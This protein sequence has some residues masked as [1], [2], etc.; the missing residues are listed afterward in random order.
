MFQPH[1]NGYLSVGKIEED[2][3]LIANGRI[4]GGGKGKALWELAK[5]LL[6]GK[7]KKVVTGAAKQAAIE[8]AKHEVKKRLHN[9]HSGASRKGLAP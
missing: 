8:V 9:D 5:K 3:S 1:L 6:K 4:L 7:C 2:Y